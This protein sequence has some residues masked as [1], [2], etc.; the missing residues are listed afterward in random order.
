ML[1]PIREQRLRQ[2]PGAKVVVDGGDPAQAGVVRGQQ[3]AERQ[4][5]NDDRRQGLDQREAA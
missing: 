4:R 1:R 3:R 2:K 5:E